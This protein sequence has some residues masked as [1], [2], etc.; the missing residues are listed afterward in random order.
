MQISII[1]KKKKKKE[2]KVYYDVKLNVINLLV[3]KKLKTNVENRKYFLK[4]IEP[5]FIKL[6]TQ[7]LKNILQ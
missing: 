3:K 1:P 5:F 6:S 7:N 4:N 2:K